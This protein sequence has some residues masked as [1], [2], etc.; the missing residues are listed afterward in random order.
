MRI[1]RLDFTTFGRFSGETINL[2][3]AKADLH[4]VYGPNEAGKTTALAA[5]ADLLFG[6]PTR[7]AFAF[8]HKPSELRIGA[9]LDG[10]RGPLEIVRRKG[11]KDTLLGP[12]GLPVPGGERVL[13]P[14]LGGADRTFFERMFSLDHHR[15]Q[16]GGREILEARNDIG[17]MLF[18]AGLGIEGIG[19]RIEELRAEADA[20]WTPRRAK[21]RAYYA[22][23][24]KLNEAD[25]KLREC[26]LSADRWHELKRAL[27]GSEEAYA[28]LERELMK[29]STERTRLGR[30]RRVYRHV[31]RKR[32]LDAELDSLGE[33]IVLPA[34]AG[35]EL[36]AAERDEAEATSTIAALKNEASR[37]RSEL[38]KLCSDQNLLA[39]ADEIRELRDRRIE[40]RNART[41]LPRQEA[42]LGAA[43]MEL[44]ALARELNLEAGDP[45]SLATRIP[46]QATI[47]AVRT[48]H[49][50]G[51]EL[52]AEVRAR[53]RAVR[54]SEEDLER[55]ADALGRAP[56]HVD[57]SK[58]AGAIESVRERG[59]L[60]G[61]IHYAEGRVKDLRARI[62]REVASLRPSVEGG[63][64]ISALNV[65]TREQVQRHLEHEREW[66]EQSRL[67][68]SRANAL[69][70]ELADARAS[71]ERLVHEEQAVSAEALAQARR[72]RDGLWNLVKFHHVDGSILSKETLEGYENDADDLAGAYERSVEHADA[73]ADRRFDHAEAAGRLVELERTAAELERRTVACDQ[74]RAR[75]RNKAREIRSAWL[76][77]WQDAPFEVLDPEPMLA[78]LDAREAILQGLCEHREAETGLEAL[79]T[80]ER[81][82]RAPVTDALV[83]LGADPKRLKTLALAELV[84]AASEEYRRHESV[85]QEH[86]RLV[87]ELDK[88]RAELER[89]NAALAQAR[90][91]S[92]SWQERWNA[93]LADVGLR[94]DTPPEAVEAQLEA[95]E[96]ARAV[97]ARIAALLGSIAGTRRALAAF[98]RSAAKL[99][100]LVAR[101]LVS[102]PADA[103]LV[104]IENR[105]A[106]AERVQGRR[107]VMQAEAGALD[108]RIEERRNVLARAASSVAHLMKAAGVDSTLALKKMIERSDR[109]RALEAERRA[110]VAR[111]SDDGDGKPV[112]ALEA[113]CTDVDL[114]Q[115]AATEAATQSEIEALH[116]RLA[117]AAEERSRARAAFEALG[118]SDAGVHAAADREDALAELRDICDR[119]VRA[120]GSALLLE[121]AVDRYRRERQAPLLKR[122]AELF[123]T[124]TAGSFTELRVDY[125][126]SDRPCLVGLRPQGD[127]VPV[128]GLSAGTADQLYLALRVAAIEEYRT[129][130]EALPFIA[131]D[132]LVNL[133]DERAAAG[134][135]V[136]NR[137]SHHTQV[138]LFTHHRHLVDI[139]RAT[140]GDSCRVVDLGSPKTVPKAA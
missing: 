63:V 25:G 85:N 86:A 45:A 136:L 49:A 116:G 81:H 20:L 103:A 12:D 74:E 118:G 10:Q 89:R 83:A 43:E 40:L 113:E 68:D 22:A 76:A 17:R 1:E 80:R 91:A 57:V 37:A 126:T 139:A 48:L 54:G 122:A 77:L 96:R 32:E 133:D 117:E 138:L 121:S 24:D 59:D 6:V 52:D 44:R 128:P 79:R 105:L 28:K 110:T 71:R 34:E 75:L 109:R 9:R 55:C 4:I 33:V 70:R 35:S 134:L 93:A 58:L 98:E 137:L 50:R 31:M 46:A 27:E 69:R 123:R 124:L 19:E 132:L 111:L 135:E 16:A 64:S 3:P 15:L 13:A 84:E 47:R 108:A 101:D 125:D 30:I 95:I 107:L 90:E 102:T 36:G 65:P 67:A 42:E 23:L 112:E 127:A 2:P 26:T 82:A 21:H 38:A 119:Y 94:A 7:T 62:E 100:E 18:S 39:R 14:Y 106:E 8:R 97:G 56:V 66:S 114:D 140:L 129:R 29:L 99:V 104:E 87:I 88:A 60:A 72:R 11:A 73:L 120:R 51:V 41:E 53:A 5:I 115:A 92:S 131:D 61:Q 78:W 130:T